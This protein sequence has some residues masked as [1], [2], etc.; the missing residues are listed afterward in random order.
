MTYSDRHRS[1]VSDFSVINHILGQPDADV[2]KLKVGSIL[3]PRGVFE[4]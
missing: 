2:G 4:S 3:V 1:Q